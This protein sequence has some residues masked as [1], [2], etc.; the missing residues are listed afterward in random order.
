MSSTNA[1]D[2]SDDGQVTCEKTDVA[3]TK[4]ADPIVVSYGDT[5]T[6]TLKARN[7]G[8]GKAENVTVTDP[9]PAGVSFV[10]ADAPC[11]F[12]AGTVTCQLGTLNPGQEV[13]LEV[14]VKVDPLAPSDPN[15]EHLLDVQKVEAQIDV[16]AGETR[17]V[18][19][20][21]PSG[22]FASDGSVRIDQVDH[23]TGDWTTQQV[24]ESRAARSTPGRALSGTRPRVAPRRRSSPSASSRPLTRST[25]T[26]TT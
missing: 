7:N 1:P 4:T 21:C 13:T 17:T 3:I 18:S 5:V 20:T 6:Y 24:L 23:G 8:P 19:V 16:Q 26:P 12:A 10:S 9:L 11:G 14:R 22:Y 2:D 25:A 15:L